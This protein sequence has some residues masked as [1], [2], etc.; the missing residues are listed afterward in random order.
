MKNEK[1]LYES[2]ILKKL[3]NF[4]NTNSEMNMQK[5]KIGENS[6]IIKETRNKESNNKIQ[7]LNNSSKTF[8]GNIE[9][10]DLKQ[11]QR[12]TEFLNNINKEDNNKINNNISS[13][14]IQ[15][16]NSNNYEN[17]KIKIN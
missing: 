16:Q 7:S 13:N 5:G 14:R 8:S 3:Q 12:N 4:D 10:K 2:L 6:K 17:R 9:A 11:C 15:M 1:I